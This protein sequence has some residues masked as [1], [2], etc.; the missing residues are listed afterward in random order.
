MAK[1]L[2]YA[3]RPSEPDSTRRLRPARDETEVGYSQIGLEIEVR[4][5]FPAPSEKDST[6]SPSSRMCARLS[7]ISSAWIITLICPSLRY[8]TTNARISWR[9][10]ARVRCPR[11]RRCGQRSYWPASA[12]LA[13]L[14]WRRG[15]ASPP[16]TIGKRRN[17]FIANRI[18]GLY[19]EMRSG[20]PRTIRSRLS[21]APNPCFPWVLVTSKA[22]PTTT[23][24]TAP[25][26][27]SPPSTY[28]TARSSP[29]ADPVIVTKSSGHCSA[30][31]LFSFA[32]G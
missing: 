20:R 9:S 31:S 6:R 26:P 27:C 24:A 7:R 2:Q 21:N 4:P 15:W 23:S 30:R 19:D 13:M 22:S 5:V 12:S 10:R 3:A 25:P 18:E 28:S 1:C 14:L 11:R 29:N 17:R 16:H 8:P 32:L